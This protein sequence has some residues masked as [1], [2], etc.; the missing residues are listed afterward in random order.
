MLLIVVMF[1]NVYVI[2]GASGFLLYVCSFVWKEFNINYYLIY[3]FLVV[4][5]HK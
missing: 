1:Q 3:S 2:Q 4:L 5:T